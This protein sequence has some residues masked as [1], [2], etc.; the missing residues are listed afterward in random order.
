MKRKNR[1]SQLT[2]ELYYRELATYK[3]RRLVEKALKTD[4]NIQNRYKAIH[5]SE[6]EFRESFSQELLRLEPHK[7][8][9]APLKRKKI[10]IGILIAAVI[11]C[12]FIPV[13]L[14]LKHNNSNKENAIAE[15]S[16]KEFETTDENYTKDNDERLASYEEEKQNIKDNTKPTEKT[17]PETTKR[18]ETQQKGIASETNKQ[19]TDF[20]QGGVSV[21]EAPK[22]DTGI[23]TRGG[24]GEQQPDNSKS[25]EQES[26]LSIPPGIT[27]IFENMFAEKQ[28]SFVVI[29]NRITS[30]RK[31]AFSGNPLVS[32]TIGANVTVDDE[33]IPGNFAKAYNNYG[34]SAGTYTRPNSNSEAWE[35]K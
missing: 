3:E 22:T 2:L 16:N 12:T 14:Y 23:H 17:K 6:Q 10:A 9:P 30:I 35:K 20:Q 18:T 15:S 8:P 34:K 27:F 31:N 7:L 26:N 24:S 4:I 28:L 21:A 5:E 25:A 29:P 11:I 1:I 32:V 13:F 19:N 33:A